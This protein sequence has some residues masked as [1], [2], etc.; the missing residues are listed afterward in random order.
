MVR[1]RLRLPAIKVR[2][3]FSLYLLLICVHGCG[4]SAFNQ[5]SLRLLVWMPVEAAS[6]CL[7]LMKHCC[8]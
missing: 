6:T 5:E 8:T 2:R 7:V 4:L 3:L 1:N